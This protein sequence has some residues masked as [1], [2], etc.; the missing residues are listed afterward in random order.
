MTHALVRTLPST[1][2]ATALVGLLVLAALWASATGFGATAST[3]LPNANVL[4]TLSMSDPTAKAADPALCTDAVAPL[5]TDN[6]SDVTF[7]GSGSS[8][9]LKLGSLSG[10]DVQAGALTWSVSTTNPTGYAVRMD[11]AGASPLLRG[12]AGSIPDMSTSTGVPQASVPGA[13][14]F[15][16]AAGNA[17]TDA[18]GSVSY[19]GSPWVTGG[20]QGELFFGVPATGSPVDVARRTGS[21]LNDPFTLTFAAASISS[22][23]PTPGTYAGTIRLIA[24]VI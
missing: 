10:T 17:A 21:Q 24:S 12:T 5:D 19:A 6:C 2:A 18:E 16:V 11:N 13:T 23:P 15:G 3:Q 20:Q 7:T 4:G 9:T 14:H 22:A 1:R 8:K